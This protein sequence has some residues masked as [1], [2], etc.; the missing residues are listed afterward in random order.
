MNYTNIRNLCKQYNI[1][2]FNENGK[3][4][5]YNNLRNKINDRENKKHNLSQKHK[6]YNSIENY[7]TWYNNEILHSSLGFLTPLEMEVKLRGNINIAA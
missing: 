4:F 7:I 2:M 3:L 6:L 5:K 1:N